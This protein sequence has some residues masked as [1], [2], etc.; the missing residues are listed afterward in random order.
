MKHLIFIL[1]LLPGLA[2]AHG[3]DTS[4]TKD[5]GKY[6][7]EFEYSTNKIIAGEFVNF[8]IHVLDSSSKQEQ[9]F[10]NIF[11]RIT[12]ASGQPALIAKIAQSINGD[13]GPTALMT[14]SLP[15]S[16]DYMAEV[17]VT[18]GGKEVA[19]TSFNFSVENS[20]VSTGVET[21]TNQPDKKLLIL[22]AA[23]SVLIGVVIGSRFKN[24]VK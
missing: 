2:L 23:A 17:T 4:L 21:K 20:A 22:G 24:N 10:D 18:I 11:V 15:D 14:G 1:F 13:E 9:N 8:G 7:I 16:G 12:K 3:T 19:K 5:T 6:T